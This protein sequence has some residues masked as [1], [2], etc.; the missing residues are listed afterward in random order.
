VVSRPGCR[1]KFDT[2]CSDRKVWPCLPSVNISAEEDALASGDRK[3]V[4][5]AHCPAL[6]KR[7]G[8]LLAQPLD[9]GGWW[10]LI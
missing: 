10:A 3:A 7:D 8:L 4:S 1:T 2:S 9:Q 5:L 6:P